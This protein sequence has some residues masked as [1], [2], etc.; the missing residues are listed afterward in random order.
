MYE[1]ILDNH[2]TPHIVVDA[3]YPE[4]Q[5]PPAYIE[6]GKITLNLSPLAVTAFAMNNEAL[7]FKASF[8]GCLRHLYIPISAITAVYAVENNHCLVFG[9][10]EV[11]KGIIVNMEGE[12][13]LPPEEGPDDTHPPKRPK[14]PPKLSI[15]K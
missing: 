5:V 14:G 1:W 10:E 9:P 8:E 3:N 7:E 2:L 15:V 12:E 6:D 11:D 13:G 4:V